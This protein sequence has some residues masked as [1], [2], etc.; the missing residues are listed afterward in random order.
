MSDWIKLKNEEH[1]DG[2]AKFIGKQLSLDNGWDEVI[3]GKN[4]G[5]D[6]LRRKKNM[7]FFRPVEIKCPTF[8]KGKLVLNFKGT[9]RGEKS[10]EEKYGKQTMLI[11]IRNQ[12]FYFE[13]QCKDID[14]YPSIVRP[15]VMTTIPIKLEVDNN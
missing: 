12:P 4:R 6:L 5:P 2:S 10:W 3:I 9:K 13:C 7:N 14:K 1:S 15:E 11:I 8:K